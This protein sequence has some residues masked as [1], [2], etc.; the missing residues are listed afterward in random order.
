[1]SES[2]RQNCGV[3]LGM[4]R[5]RERFEI[6]PKWMR[7]AD[8]RYG[9]ASGRDPGGRRRYLLRYATRGFGSDRR[10][11][12]EDCTRPAARCSRILTLGSAS[13]A[14]TAT[15]VSGQTRPFVLGT[16]YK[17]LQAYYRESCTRTL[18]RWSKPL[19]DS[20]EHMHFL[21]TRGPISKL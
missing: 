9:G 1:M 3:C 12:A 21:P 11:T 13:G 5:L 19:S 17:K 16:I 10:K 8:L 20:K 18:L 2:T 4:Q 14:H 7:I 6:C 15:R